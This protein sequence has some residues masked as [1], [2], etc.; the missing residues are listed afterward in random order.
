MHAKKTQEHMEIWKY[1][2]HDEPHENTL[3]TIKFTAVQTKSYTETHYNPKLV[4]WGND[5]FSWATELTELN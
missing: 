3:T 2:K 1:T 5:M 4:K